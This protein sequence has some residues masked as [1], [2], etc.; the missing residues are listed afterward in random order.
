M[1]TVLQVFGIVLGYI[2]SL[3][4]NKQRILF[5]ACLSNIVS[6]LLF[7]VTG[8][9]DGV[10]AT[11]IIGIRCI[12]FLFKD[13][14]KTSLVL[15]ICVFAHIVCGVITFADIYSLV[16]LLT[17]VITCLT[18]WYG[19]ALVIK[20]V[21]IFV[22]TGWVVYYVYIHLYLT[23]ANTVINVLLTLTA[24]IQLLR[25]NSVDSK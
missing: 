13:N 15:W 3:D 10:A 20:C 7:I 21:S 16:P 22:N 25:S 17:T 14:Y 11:V 4:K 23:A 8:R 12:L 6:I 9:F 5:Y 18:Y 2:G 24:I 1:D 19:N